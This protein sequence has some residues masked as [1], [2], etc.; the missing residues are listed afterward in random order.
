M[1]QAVSPAS[2]NVNC[3]R[4]SRTTVSRTCSFAVTSAVSRFVAMVV[5]VVGV[6]AQ[7]NPLQRAEP[8]EELRPLLPRQARG[9]REV[10]V[11]ADPLQHHAGLLQRATGLADAAHPPMAARDLDIRFQRLGIVLITV[12]RG[13]IGLN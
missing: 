9:A 7:T 8:I 12:G 13:R 4:D 5:E 10:G 1:S 6:M 11:G 2:I 3:C